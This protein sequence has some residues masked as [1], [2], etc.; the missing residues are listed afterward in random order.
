MRQIHN[1]PCILTRLL[2]LPL[3][4]I[5]RADAAQA[6]GAGVSGRVTD[7]QGDAIANVTVTLVLDGGEI[8]RQKTTNAE[9]RFTFV[10]IPEGKYPIR[11]DVT[12]FEPVAQAVEIRNGP[13]PTLDVQLKLASAEQEVRVSTDV[14][15]LNVRTPDPAQRPLVGQETLDANPGRPGAPVSVPG[16]PIETASGGI[17]GNGLR[18]ARLGTTIYR[19]SAS[20][21]NPWPGSHQRS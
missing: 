13:L 15:D 7:P 2:C 4:L 6:Q 18:A 10:A 12:G 14:L 9:G 20:A 21:T 11:L 5:L 8:I 16:I 17:N 19:S 3:F 1:R